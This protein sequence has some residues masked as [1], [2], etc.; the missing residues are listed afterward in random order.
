MR[1]LGCRSCASGQSAVESR[2]MAV[3]SAESCTA[4]R[5][6]PDGADD[7]VQLPVLRQAGDGAGLVERVDLLG[8][9]VA[10]RT[11]TAVVG[12]ASPIA[13]VVSTPSSSGRR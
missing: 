12:Q 4:P 6:I 3:F 2:T 13:A 11:T 10:V 9:G 1:Q 7:L 5:G 8:L